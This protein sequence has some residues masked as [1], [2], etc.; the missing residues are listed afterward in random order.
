MSFR[1]QIMLLWEGRTDTAILTEY[2]G[3]GGATTLKT[4]L[5]VPAQ[6]A[7]G[8]AF[9]DPLERGGAQVLADVNITN[10]GARERHAVD[11]ACIHELGLGQDFWAAEKVVADSDDVAHTNLVGLLLVGTLC[12]GH[13]LGIRFERNVAQLLLSRRGRRSTA[14]AATVYRSIFC[15]AGAQQEAW[16]SHRE[17]A[18]AVRSGPPSRTPGRGRA[19]LGPTRLPLKAPGV[20]G[21]LV[22]NAVRNPGVLPTKG[23]CRSRPRFLVDEA[24]TDAAARARGGEAPQPKLGALHSSKPLVL[25]RVAAGRLQFAASAKSVPKTVH[26]QTFFGASEFT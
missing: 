7:P 26:L 18:D 25:L 23:V 2:L 4:S 5:A 11:S 9:V 13:Q 10:R 22:C 24:P 16:V 19:S 15:T 20:F 8:H 14:M 12:C 21:V 3:T 6:S 1:A 17:V